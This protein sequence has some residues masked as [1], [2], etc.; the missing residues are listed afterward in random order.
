MMIFARRKIAPASAAA[1]ATLWLLPVCIPAR[2]AQGALAAP[3]MREVTDE[4]GRRVE[5]PV[6]VRRIVSIA[7]NLTET[8]YAL[9]AQDRLVGDTDYCDYPPEARQKPHVGSAINPSLEAIV[10]LKPDLV[11]AAANTINRLPTVQ[12]L[13]RIGV[14]VYAADPHTVEEVI[15][16]TQRVA[17]LIGASEEG[18]ALASRLEARLDALRQRLAGRPPVRALFVVWDEPFI[19]IGPHSFLADALRRAGAESVIKAKQDWPQVSLEEVVHQQPDV[20]I[21]ASGDRESGEREFES[22][23]TRPGWRELRAVREKHIAI[24]SDAINRPAPRLVDAIEQLAWDLH[25]DAFAEKP[26]EAAR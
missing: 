26:A 6:V 2:A 22:L 25:P 16:S 3:A 1:L 15:A 9:G 7:P 18:K 17:D 11:L 8:I 24:V 21:F 5:I 10:A 23:A 20:L 4:T 13:E 14:A 19:S 12:A